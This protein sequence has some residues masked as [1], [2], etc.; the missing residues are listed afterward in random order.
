MKFE[1]RRAARFH[2]D[3]MF[4]VPGFRFA[5]PFFLSAIATPMIPARLFRSRIGVV[6]PASQAD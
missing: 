1:R 3:P 6:S 4:A 5:N 2:H